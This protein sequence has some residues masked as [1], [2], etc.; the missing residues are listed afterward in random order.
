[1][2][3]MGESISDIAFNG[4]ISAIRDNDIFPE[5]KGV[6]KDISSQKFFTRGDF[7]KTIRIRYRKIGLI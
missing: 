3:F 1:M 7:C 4:S 5:N 2:K 6:F